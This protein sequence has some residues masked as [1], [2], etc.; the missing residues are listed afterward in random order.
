MLTSSTLFTAPS[1]GVIRLSPDQPVV[2]LEARSRWWIDE[3]ARA[4]VDDVEAAGEHLPWATQARG[5][6]F[7]LDG[8]ALWE[9]FDAQTDMPG[10]WFVEVSS[11]GVDRVQMFYRDAAQRWV[12]QEAGDTRPVSAWPLPGRVPTFDMSPQTGKPVRYWLRVEHAR[13]DFAS[14]ISIYHQGELFAA[15]E[16][17]QFMLG[18]YFG[19]SVLIA[20]V[21]AGNAI[22]YR[23][24]TFATYA[25]Y[26]A[27]LALGQ[28]AYL[29]V[30]A[31]HLWDR[32]LKWNEISTFL[33]PGLSASAAL[34]FVRTV[35]EPARFSRALDLAVWSLIL[36]LLSAVALDTWLTSRATFGLQ[37]ALTAL[38]IVAVIGLILYVWV[39]GDDPHIRL[40]A[41]GFVPVLAMAVFPVLRG[42]NLI[43]VS[44]LTRYG[45]TIG[46]MIEMPILF[47]A[48]MLRANRRREAEV[49]ASAL[50]RND[51]LTGLAHT[52]TLLQRLE[53]ALT[54]A[55]SLRH[56]C[57]LMAVRIANFDAIV[58]E[59]GRDAIE[60][61]LVVAASH[62][63]RAIGDIDLAAR[64]GNHDFALLLEGPT[65]T[66]TALSKAQ[67][68]IASGLRQADALPPG[69]TI[70]FHVAVALLPDQDYDAAASLKWV[71]GGV[72]HMPND[73]RKLIRPLNF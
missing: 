15:R 3:S 53:A 8:K 62:L 20:L 43:P 42:L 18:A 13:V 37:M 63:R 30:G 14:P 66:S 61:V 72:T 48:L 50:S 31:Q 59:F 16:R 46:A 21:S 60:K 44:L 39:Q 68:V 69:L 54:R 71:L 28:A 65:S 4:T 55:R 25:V 32:A 70:K 7:K 2:P 11:S 9:A 22:A 40:I 6:Q 56:P 36:A 41:L 38:A 64:V 10:R 52:R 29:G 51:A 58:A 19:L 47:Y 23:D 34:W 73:A 27:A 35:T 24:R 17:E 57:A 1:P 45:V 26:V 12:V 67:H 5:R 49:R 33:L